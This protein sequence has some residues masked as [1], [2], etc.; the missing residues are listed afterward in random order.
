MHIR[1]WDD[2]LKYGAS[3]VLQREYG[4]LI[5]KDVEA[6]YNISLEIDLEQV[7]TD[8]GV[9]L[10]VTSMLRNR[11]INYNRGSRCVCYVARS[12]EA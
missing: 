1:C 8:P 12:P 7:P 4:S 11:F 10:L 2:L 3:N 9:F 6:D 5:A